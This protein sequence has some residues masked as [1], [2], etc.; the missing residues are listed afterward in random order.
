MRR[1]ALHR[2]YVCQ[3][4]KLIEEL[5]VGLSS[6]KLKKAM[7][8]LNPGGDGVVS[9]EDFMAWYKEHGQQGEG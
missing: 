4:E 9:R 8:S 7:A 2:V 6:K 5:G 1:S 3:A